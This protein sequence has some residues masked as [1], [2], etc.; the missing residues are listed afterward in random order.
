LEEPDKDSK[1]I[2]R[3]HLPELKYKVIS[4]K[5]RS[6]FIVDLKT[7]NNWTQETAAKQEQQKEELLQSMA[8]SKKKIN[9]AS[10]KIVPSTSHDIVEELDRDMKTDDL[11]ANRGKFD[12][13]VKLL[14]KDIDTIK[15]RKDCF[16]QYKYNYRGNLNPTRKY[17]SEQNMAQ[18]RFKNRKLLSMWDEQFKMERKNNKKQPNYLAKNCY[19]ISNLD[20]K[21]DI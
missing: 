16:N 20:T 13:L 10:F 5:N 17:L 8:S 9:K 21:F 14:N 19:N 12:H 6:K 2:M 18:L 11:Y 1:K 3:D 4:L 7:R 15:A